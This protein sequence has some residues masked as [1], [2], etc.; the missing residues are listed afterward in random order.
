MGKKAVPGVTGF[1]HFEQ[2]RPKVLRKK[3]TS[4]WFTLK[5]GL[6]IKPNLES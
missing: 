3:V 5:L 2:W 6:T 1:S 4:T